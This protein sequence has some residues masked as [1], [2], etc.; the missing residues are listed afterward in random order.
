MICGL[1]FGRAKQCKDSTAGFDTVYLFPFVKY[2]KSQ[3][4]TDANVVTTF[5]STTIYKFEVLSANLTEDQSEEGGGKFYSQNIS[6]DLPKFDIVDNLELVKLIK[7]DYRAIVL[8]RNG[9][10]RIVGLYNGLI[11]ELSKVTGSGKQ[12]FNGYKLTMEGQEILSA[13]FITDLE[14]A[15]FVISEDN[16]LLL[17]NGEFI[18]LEN[19]ERIILE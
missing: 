11:S 4:I 14:D 12:D 8:D 2:S 7:K 19:N 6:F 3:I 10:Y 13:L 16:F 1:T 5:P 15:G 18:L 9:N 17:E